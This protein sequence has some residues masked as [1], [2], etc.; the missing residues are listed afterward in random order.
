M[1]KEIKI[2]VCGMRDKE[3]L[4]Q[5]ITLKPD[6]V[7]FIFYEKSP[8]FVGNDFDS[9]ISNLIPENTKKVGVFVNADGNY[10]EDKIIRYRLNCVQ[11]HGNENLSLCKEISSKGVE[12]IKSF[13]IDEKFDFEVLNDYSDCCNYF[14]FDTKTSAY[15]G[16]GKKFD[17]DILKTLKNEKPFF[18]SGGIDPHD[19]I[20][21][22]DFGDLPLYAVDIN[23]RFEVNAGLKDIEL[24]R[25]FINKI[26]SK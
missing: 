19:T 14:L 21:T 11:L 9:S 6:F 22:V 10:I 25:S 16:S 20:R 1:S 15:G 12:V 3:N 4:L 2:K 13:S 18:L 17:W 7:G 8:R 26:R 24:V 23:S 5:L